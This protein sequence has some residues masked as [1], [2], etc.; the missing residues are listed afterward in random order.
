MSD[1]PNISYADSGVDIDAGNAFVGR[2]QQA[3]ASTTRKEVLAGLGGFGAL[4]AANFKGYMDPVLV[5]GTDGVGTKLLLHQQY[6]TPEHAGQDVVAMCVNDIAAQG[7]EPLFFL[8]YLATGKL[9]GDTLV[10]VV[11]GIAKACRISGCALIGGETAEMPGMYGP[12]H[13]DIAGFSVG[14]VDRP[15]IIDGSTIAD[16][17]VILGLASSGP[18]SNGYSLIRKLLE[19]G[20]ADLTKDRLSDGRLARDGVLAPTRLYVPAVKTLMHAH[21]DVHGFAHITGGGMYDN[22]ERIMPEGLAAHVDVT[23]WKIPPVFEYLLSFA[24]V[25]KSERYR[26]LNM[27]IGFV[28]FVPESAQSEVEDLLRRAGEHVFTIGQVTARRGEP[29]ILEGLH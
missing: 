18:H 28:V 10:R 26:T 13:Y 7:A 24:N 2:I 27:G 25:A 15:R 1:K 20:K 8:D 14:I 16:G 9:E 3:V 17:D 19:I 22:L 5:S 4:F 21:V 12:G 29:V 6:D 23:S 11:E